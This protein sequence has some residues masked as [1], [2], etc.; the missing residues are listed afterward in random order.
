MFAPEPDWRTRHCAE[1]VAETIRK[2]AGRDIW[3]E[4]GGCPRS[5]RDAAAL[6]RRAGVRSLPELMTKLFGPPI[7]RRQARRGDAAMVR[8]ALGIV[9]GEL[10][11]CMGATV[12]LGEGDLFWS[13][14]GHRLNEE[15]PHRRDGRAAGYPIAAPCP[16]Q[17]RACL[18]VHGT[19][20]DGE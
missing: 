4:L 7:D 15:T 13:G 17:D 12:P 20:R 19:E 16:K 5:W 10:I 8:G 2:A 11:E 9:R 3:S 14:V 18:S 1:P 6:Y